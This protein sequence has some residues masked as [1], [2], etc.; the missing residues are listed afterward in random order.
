VARIDAVRGSGKARDLAGHVVDQLAGEVRQR[1][2]EGLELVAT[3]LEARIRLRAGWRIGVQTG[4]FADLRP[5]LDPRVQT[6]ECQICCAW[7][8][9]RVVLRKGGSDLL[10]LRVAVHLGQRL[11]LGSTVGRSTG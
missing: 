1:A 5:S 7:T 11:A 8:V 6:G 3:L 9:V 2:D 4:A 10:A